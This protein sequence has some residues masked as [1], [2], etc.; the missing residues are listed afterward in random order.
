MEQKRNSNYID[1]HD[2]YAECGTLLNDGSWLLVKY[3]GHLTIMAGDTDIKVMEHMPVHITGGVLDD[4]MALEW[5]RACLGSKTGRLYFAAGS[6][7][8]KDGIKRQ[9]YY[10]VNKLAEDNGAQ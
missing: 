6:I 8:D 2:A 10:A 3:K 4:P 1:L 5:L 9:T 7:E